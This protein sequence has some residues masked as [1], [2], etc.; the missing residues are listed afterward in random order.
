MTCIQS[1]LLFT[2]PC[3]LLLSAPKSYKYMNVCSNARQASVVP[4]GL[5]SKQSHHT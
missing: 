2:I 1:I 3:A 5:S 4:E